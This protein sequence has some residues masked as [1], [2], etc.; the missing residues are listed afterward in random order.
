MTTLLDLLPEM[1]RLGGREA[2]RSFDGLRT[3]RLS[4]RQLYARIGGFVR[5][6]DRRGFRK[7][8]R[9]LLWGENRPEW[10]ITFYGCLA[11]GVEVVPVDFHTSDR[12]V[13][14]VQQ[15]VGARLLVCGQAVRPEGIQ[16][17]RL[18]FDEMEALGEDDAFEVSAVSPDDVVEIVY[19]SGTTGDPRGVVHRHRNICANLRHFRPE[20][21]RYK[22]VLRPLQPIRILDLLPL[23]HMFGQSL[24]LFIPL[25]VEGAAVFTRDLG[26]SAIIE[27][28]R[29]ERVSF[30]ASVPRLLQNL[31]NE[32]ERRFAPPATPPE[33]ETG[34]LR[35]WWRYRRVHAAFGWKFWGFVVG[36][37]QVDPGL[38]AF[39]SWLGL[40]IVQGYG[41]TETS[42][43][44]AVNHPFRAR[45][46]T[47]GKAVRGLEVRLAPDGEILVRGESVVSEVLGPG[48]KAER[49]SEDGWFHTGD[50]GEMD[51]EGRLYYRGRKKD[52]IVTSSG[53]NVHPQDVEAVLNRLP[54]VREGVVIGLRLDGEEQVHAAL[55]LRDPSADPERL[56]RQANQ[57]LEPHQ[58]IRAWS[59]WPDEDFPR[60]PSTLK[61]KRREV[62]E[63]LAAG[64]GQ[65]A[66]KGETAGLEG[67][68]ARMTGRAAS[69]ITSDHRLV[70]DLSLSSLER[71]DLLSEL[72]SRY[73]TDLDEETFTRIA[74][75]GELKAWVD[76]Q[77]KFTAENTEKAEGRRQKA[78]ENAPLPT[79]H[80]P[81]TQQR[82]QDSGLRTQDSLPRWAQSL[83]V[84]WARLAALQAVF[85]PLFRCYVHLSVEGVEH[86]K[87]IQPPLLFAANHTS[88]F[89]TPVLLAAL[90]FRWRR[91]LAP[92]MMQEHF[93]AHFQ[94]EGFSL[95]QRLWGAIQ[96][97]IAC[98][99][100]SGY[101][102]PRE[103]GGVRRALQYTGELIDRG[104]CPLVYPEGRRTPDGSL[105]PFR[106]GVGLMAVRLR[107]PV[108]PV[109]I[110]GL[111]EVFSVHHRW[112][113]PGRV[114]V[115][116]GPPLDLK[117][118][119][120][121]QAAAREVEDAVRAL[122]R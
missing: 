70:E 6:L 49:V 40:L 9:L 33:K 109:H 22:K 13:R 105:H 19:T 11:R 65:A 50:I 16:I 35:R 73:Q 71:V 92:A 74:T 114:R 88:H 115:R 17:E 72:E 90:P 79:P 69:D 119:Q 14:R 117:D 54:E 106:P 98:G 66:Q 60:T 8:D 3:R 28:V 5:E 93:R 68:L 89:D 83:P 1:R 111:F 39:W 67:I 96:Y 2:V 56:I 36:G 48:G 110:S 59:L 80:S 27:T 47:L 86:L 31:Q 63:R 62:A 76:Q 42:P 52:V 87:G 57:D 120:D 53:L 85:L 94:P 81:L 58:R 23:S 51:E 100:F 15:E 122:E 32:V 108:V 78:E 103:M 61:V 18:S 112:P 121:Y 26:A 41:L 107:V 29:R 21:A 10:V 38:E 20:I 77:K 95:R 43:V 45:R 75:V 37:A 64:Q 99:L 91:R 102:L 55:L 30:L 44:V 24:G 82:T 25:L 118:V 34:L 116:I 97:L 12:L 84:R 46:G 4:Y 104:L 113:R 7:G 101:P